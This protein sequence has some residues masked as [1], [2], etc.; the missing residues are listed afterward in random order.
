L[1][2]E[3]RPVEIPF[4]LIDAFSDRPFGGNPACVC[5]LDSWLDDETLHAIAVEHNKYT[6]FFVAN[7]GDYDLR[8]FIPAGELELCGHATL[9]SAHVIFDYHEPGRRSVTFQTKG[10]ALGAERVDG[11]IEIQL[12]TFSAEP[13]AD[14]DAVA[15]ALGARP[16]EVLSALDA[17]AA[18]E[19]EAEIRELAP[20][21]AKLA[22]LDIRGVMATAPGDE[23]EIDYVLRFFA[24]GAGVP[25]DPV[26]ATAQGMAAPYWAGRLGKENL[27]A[28]QLSARGG[29]VIATPKGDHVAVAGPAI[30]NQ[31][32]LITL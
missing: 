16:V 26:T 2:P 14:A 5:P 27:R 15:E 18:F 29:A 4:Y 25:E 10:G 7:G 12:P 32:G 3:A 6:A 13:S 8:W 31:I 17:L 19:S 22:A 20:D 21:M 1:N 23:P 11:M 28:R 30:T 9:A 24:P